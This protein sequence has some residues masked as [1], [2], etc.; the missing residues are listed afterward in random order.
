MESM[1]ARDFMKN[2]FKQ[3]GSRLTVNTAPPHRRTWLI[4]TILLVSTAFTIGLSINNSAN[5]ASPSGTSIPIKKGGTGATDKVNALTNLLP[6]LAGNDGKVLGLQGG[7][8]SWVAQAGNLIMTP[9]YT[10]QET[11]NLLDNSDYKT[12][13]TLPAS[14]WT[15]TVYA[16]FVAPK[17]GYYAC[18]QTFYANPASEHS[19]SFIAVNSKTV[20]AI[21]TPA[22]YGGFNMF[23]PSVFQATQGDTITLA[24]GTTPTVATNYSLTLDASNHCYFI[25]PK[26]S[27][28]PQPIVVEGGDYDKNE[29]QVMVNDNGTQRPKLSVNRKP[30]YVRT[31]ERNYT[32]YNTNT[33]ATGT[34]EILS[35]DNNIEMIVDQEVIFV[36]NGNTWSVNGQV[37]YGSADYDGLSYVMQITSNGNDIHLWRNIYDVGYTAGTFYLTAYYTK[38]TDAPL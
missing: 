12:S 17:T 38:T 6:D 33:S 31:F 19:Q 18:T 37:Y 13:F 2:I 9:D 36:H 15:S 34:S 24:I 29:R 21:Y 23:T 16:K 4:T 1:K 35:D 10:K 3:Q 7:T 14:T 28:P 32:T 22:L 11:T 26:Y 25:P 30:I 27:T 5:G 20:A 8:P